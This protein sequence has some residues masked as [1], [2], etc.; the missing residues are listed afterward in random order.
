M[1][2]QHKR[3]VREAVAVFHDVSD[4]DAAVQ[5]LR[6]AGFA[7]DDI[8]LLASEEA[9]AR[10]LGH[11]Y[12]RVEELE[13]DPEAPRVAYRTRTS[14]G[15]RG[16]A[17]RFAHLPASSRGRRHRGGI[18]RRGRGCRDRHR[19]RRRLDRH[20]ARA[21][22]GQES[23]R[24]PAGAARPW[25]SSALG[26]HAGQ[27]RPA[28]RPRGPD[29]TLGARR[30]HPPAAGPDPRLIA[31]PWLARDARPP[32]RCSA[33]HDTQEHQKAWPAIRSDRAAAVPDIGKT[34][35]DAPATP[36]GKTPCGGE[37]RRPEGASSRAL[38]FYVHCELCPR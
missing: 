10:K 26:A 4:L 37:G 3:V 30:P 29:P 17:D 12:E 8:S 33:D 32:L 25:R 35:R 11:R 38:R 36:C 28:P 16:S 14:L 6:A 2:E 27:G 18:G 19:D 23:R 22:A 5:E 20:G 9:V 24:T 7:K 21:L 31:P 15:E 13:D 34:T 1:P